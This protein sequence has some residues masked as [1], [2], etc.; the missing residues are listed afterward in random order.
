MIIYDVPFKKR[1]EKTT[2]RGKP[3]Y[4]FAGAEKREKK[5]GGGELSQ[6]KG[7]K[8]LLSQGAMGVDDRIN[9]SSNTS[10]GHIAQLTPRS[11]RDLGYPSQ[12]NPQGSM[13]NY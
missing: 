12:I 8:S 1:G 9:I 7:G 13:C 2:R 4:S 11:M 6:I 10:A 3:R 5:K